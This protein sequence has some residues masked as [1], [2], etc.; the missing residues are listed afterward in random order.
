MKGIILSGG[1]ATRLFPLTATTSKQLLPVYNRQMI[2]YPLNMLI[3]A[4]IKNILIIVAPEHSGQ[5]LNLLGSTMKKFGINIYFD[6]QKV[7]RGLA[8]AFILGESFIGKSSVTMILG[9]NIFEDDIS[10]SIRNFKSGGM[11]FAKQ[12]SD[13]ERFGIVEFD[14]DGKALSIEEKP[15][16]PK[17]NFCVTGA[18]IYDNR[19]IEIAKNMKP[20]SRGEIEITDVNNAFLGMREL[21]VKKIEGEWLDAGTFDSLLEAGNIVKNKEIY[22]NFDPIIDQAILEFNEELKILAKKRLQ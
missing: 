20:S 4:G 8:D 15:E 12:V 19:V 11:I 3:K 22:K 17:S 7:P 13:P 16:K 6:V 21:T 9:D 14:E 1:T 18:Y 10:K 2:F 5:Y